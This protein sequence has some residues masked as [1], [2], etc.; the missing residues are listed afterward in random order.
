MPLHLPDI[1][2]VIVHLGPLAIRWYALAYVF[3]IV[4][5]WYYISRMLKAERL[6]TPRSAPLEPSQLDDLI[7]WITLGVILGGRIGYILFYD[8]S[9]IWKDPVQVFTIWQGGMSFHGGFLGVIIATVGYSLA[10]KFPASRMLNLGDLLAAAAPIGLFAG[11]LANFVNGELWGRPTHVPWGMVFCNKY[12]LQQYNGDC[13][14][15]HDPLTGEYHD[16]VRHPSQL[17]E[18]F[19]EGLLLFSIIALLIWR[20]GRLRRPGLVMGTFVTGYAIIRILLENVREPDAQMLPFF[21]NVITMGQSLSLLMLVAGMFF[22]WYALR[23]PPAATGETPKPVSADT[24][25][26]AA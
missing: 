11:R 14:A 18:A 4:A 22:I 2:P 19:G 25:D 12:I 8:A 26:A 23:E 20:F 3:G 17:Y 21:K 10:K 16:V 7:L 5:G 6:W 13:P 9:I 15:N 1:D 24:P